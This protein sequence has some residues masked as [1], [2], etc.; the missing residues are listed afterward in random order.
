MALVGNTIYVANTDAVVSFPYLEGVTRIEQAGKKIADL[1]GGPINHHWTK[2][3]V[4]NK[5]GSK[6]Y[7]SVGSN[8]N[9]AENGLNNED[10][11]ASI[12][13]IDLASGQSRVFASGLRNPVGMD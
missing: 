3:L 10:K 12:H 2:G 6:L 13:E 4:A 5:D 11:R 7:A 8:S 1:P 9:A